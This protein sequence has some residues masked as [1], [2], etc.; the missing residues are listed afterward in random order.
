MLQN[1]N[2]KINNTINFE[3]SEKKYFQA[4][5]NSS[6]SRFNRVVSH[7]NLFIYLNSVC[8]KIGIVILYNSFR[9]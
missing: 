7:F 2:V 4:V 8:F 5:I 6:Q 1:K 9:Y 3:L